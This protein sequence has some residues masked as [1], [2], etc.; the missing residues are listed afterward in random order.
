MNA[1]ANGQA[2]RQNRTIISAIGA[3]TECESRWDE[4]LGEIVWRMNHCVNASTGFS[5]AQLMFSH[6]SGVVADLSGGAEES[7]R[8]EGG[9][10]FQDIQQA[11]QARREKAAKT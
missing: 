10:S 8:V 1:I 6:S 5:P 9:E 7:V 4:K 2:E 3:S 11:V